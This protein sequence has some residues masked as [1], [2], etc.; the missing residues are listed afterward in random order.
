MRTPKL[1]ISPPTMYLKS[2]S[3]KKSP[4]TPTPTF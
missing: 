4:N 2:S 1:L 3:T